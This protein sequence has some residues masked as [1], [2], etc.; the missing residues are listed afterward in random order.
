MGRATTDSLTNK[1]LPSFL[2]TTAAPGTPVAQT[3]YEDS[4]VKGWVVFDVDGVIDDD[5]NVSS[6]TDGGVGDWTVNWATAFANA[7]YGI[8]CTSQSDG[9]SSRVFRVHDSTNPTTTAV[10]T[11]MSDSTN[12]SADPTGG[13][14]TRL[15]VMAIGNS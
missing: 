7:N 12:T 13:A 2:C 15:Y 1:T 4:I 6:I 14:R 3:V 10:R 5:L 11:R 8:S 9:S